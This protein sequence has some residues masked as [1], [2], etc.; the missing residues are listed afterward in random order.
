[1][2]VL[3]AFLPCLNVSAPGKGYRIW[4]KTCKIAL[5]AMLEANAIFIDTAK[6]IEPENRV[7]D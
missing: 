3:G 5:K 6:N 7:K 4:P 2:P 1:V